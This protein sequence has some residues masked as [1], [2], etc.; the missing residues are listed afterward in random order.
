MGGGGLI[1]FFEEDPPCLGRRVIKDTTY[2]VNVTDK[3]SLALKFEL[4]QKYSAS[5][6]QYCYINKKREV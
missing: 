5:K 4:T 2:L 1:I 3:I 6:S